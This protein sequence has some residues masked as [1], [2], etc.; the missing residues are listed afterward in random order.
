MHTCDNPSCCNPRHLNLGTN[1]DNVADML[2]KGR[3]PN[4]KLT[5]EQVKEIELSKDKQR[6]IAD[7]YGI[8]QSMVSRIRS[9]ARW[10][11][12]LREKLGEKVE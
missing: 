10:K 8:S 5:I 2:R 9:G 12:D 6:E 7:R 4:A 1:L 3:A 11:A